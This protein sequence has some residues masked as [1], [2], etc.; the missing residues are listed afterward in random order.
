MKQSTKT[1]TKLVAA[2]LAA[3]MFLSMRGDVQTFAY[4]ASAQG[5]LDLLTGVRIAS[6][7][8]ERLTYSPRWGD[9]ST[10]VV[11]G[12]GDEPFHAGVEGEVEWKPVGTGAHLLRHTA[13]ATVYTAQFT[14]L[15][16]GISA[17]EG[18]GGTN[19]TWAADK[20]HLVTADVVVPSGVSLT[21]M[22]GAIV[23]F[24]TGTSLRVKD[25][26]SCTAKGVVFTHVDD[27]TVGGDVLCD[28]GR[29]AVPMGDYAISGSLIDDDT[30]EYRYLPPQLL[31]GNVSGDV[32]LR[33]HRT[34]IVSNS[35]TVAS[36]ATLTISAGAI[37]KFNAGCSL[38]VNGSLDVRGT[39]AA[40]IVFTS[41]KD[42]AHGGDTNGDGDATVASGGDWDGIWIDGKAD[43]AYAKMMYS[44]SWNESGIIQTTGGALSMTGCTLAHARN[45]GVWN[46][47]GSV[48]ATN[49]VFFDTGWATAP[50]RGTHNEFVN[51]VFYGNDVGICYWSHWS[52]KP[53]YRNCVFSNCGK[54]WCER[55]S[56]SYGDPPNAVEVFNSLFWNP[57]GE[58]LQSCGAVGSNGNIWGDPGFVDP[59]NGDFRILAASPCVD[60]GDGTAVSETDFYGRPRMDVVKVEDTGVPNVDGICPD[61]GIYEVDGWAAVD[62]ADF[63]LVGGV[64]VDASDG[65]VV[66]G[67]E[68]AISYVVTNLLETVEGTWRDRVSFVSDTGR[69]VEVAVVESSGI[70]RKGAAVTFSR[71]VRVP[72][73]DEG[74]WRVA[75]DVNPWRDVFE[76]SGVDN[77]SG[78][79]E[80]AVKVVLPSASLSETATGVVDRGA[81]ILRKFVAPSD[82]DY[83]L[84]ISAPAGSTVAYAVGAVPSAGMAMRVA[85]GEDGVVRVS[86]PAGA[87]VYVEVSGDARGSVAMRP[88]KAG[89]S[90]LDVFPA[91]LPQSGEVTLA[92]AG[93]HF[94]EGV[95]VR[96]VDGA[97]SVEAEAV[98]VE[99]AE[100][101]SARFDCAGLSAGTT[102][103]LVVGDDGAEA[104]LENAVR[105]TGEKGAAK[106]E[107]SLDMPS[108]LRQGRSFTF[109]IDYANTGNVD[110]PAPVFTVTSDELVFTTDS[111]V[112]SNSVRVIGLGAAGS[113]GTLRPGES[114]RMAVT[115]KVK[116]SG[117]SN[118]RVSY[119]LSSS[120]TGAEG[121]EEPLDLS[122]FFSDD[123]VYWHGESEQDEFDAIAET[124]G[125]TW[126]DFYRNFGAYLTYLDGYGAASHDYEAMAQSF[127]RHCQS[128]VRE[129]MREA[130]SVQPVAALCLGGNARAADSSDVE[131]VISADGEET[132]WRIPE[133]TT[134]RSWI[135][136]TSSATLRNRTQRHHE[137]LL[138]DNSWPGDVWVF[139]AAESGST[140]RYA[141]WNR[142]W[143]TDE[144]GGGISRQWIA[145][146]KTYLLCHGNLHSIHSKWIFDMAKAL[147]TREPGC[148]VLAIDWGDFSTMSSY[149]T[150]ERD[151]IFRKLEEDATLINGEDDF[152]VWTGTGY[153]SIVASVLNSVKNN[154][155]DFDRKASRS[156]IENIDPYK[157]FQPPLFR[158]PL[159]E[160]ADVTA[161][162]LPAVAAVAFQRLKNVGVP[163]GLLTLIGHSHGSHVA[164]GV[165]GWYARE[166][167][168]IS[169]LIGLETS[170]MFPHRNNV[171]EGLKFGKLWD[172]D[173]A[174]VSEFY[175]SSYWMSMGSTG[176]DGKKQV[177]G[178]YNF[179]LVGLCDSNRRFTE[180]HFEYQEMVGGD[181][182]HLREFDA[183]T[184]EG[185]MG[186][187]RHDSVEF[188]FIDTIVNK[189]KWA[190]LGFNWQGDKTRSAS[191][192]AFGMPVDVAARHKQKYHGVINT[193]RG[194]LELARPEGWEGEWR[195]EEQVLAE[196]RKLNP[197]LDSLQDNVTQAIEY[198]MKDVKVPYSKAKGCYID[199]EDNTVSFMVENAADNLSVDYADVDKFWMRSRNKAW[200]PWQ[201]D[202]GVGVWLCRPNEADG[203][204]VEELADATIDEVREKCRHFQRIRSMK[205][206]SLEKFTKPQREMSDKFALDVPD[207]FG[208]HEIDSEDG[209][210]FLLVIGAGVSSK[211]DDNEISDDY[212]GDL[213]PS[214]NWF[215]KAVTVMPVS[216]P[217]IK[218]EGHGLREDGDEVHGLREDG[219]EVNVKCGP[220]GTSVKLQ[221]NADRC[222]KKVKE[223]MWVSALDPEFGDRDGKKTSWKIEMPLSVNSK[224]TAVTLLVTYK[225][226]TTKETTVI[227]RITRK[228]NPPKDPNGGGS[229]DT[230]QSWDPNEMAGPLGAGDFLT[231]RYAKAGGWMTY[232]VFFENKPEATA[233]AQFV[234]VDNPL[235]PYLDWSTFEM[236]DVGFGTQTDT[237]LVGVKSGMSEVTMDGTNLAVRTEVSLDEKTGVVSWLMRIVSPQGDS[238]GWPYADDPTGFLPP[239][240]P[241][242]HC[243]EGHLTYRVK[244]RDDVPEGVVITN[245]A[246]IVFDYN[247][248][249]ETDPA[250]WNT[251]GNVPFDAADPKDDT[252]KG[253]VNWTL[254]STRTSFARTLRDDDPADVFKI[255]G[256]DGCL[257][258]IAIEK[259]NDNCDAVFSI[260][261]ANGKTVVD[262]NGNPVANVASARCIVL[263][264]TSKPYYLVVKHG[265][266]A[267]TGGR[268][269]IAGLCADVGSIKFA[270]TAVTVKE[271]VVYADVTVNRTGKDG[272]VR[273]RYAMADGTA[274]AGEDYQTTVGVLEW[275]NGDRKAK[276]IRIPLIPDLVAAYDGVKAKTF[277]VR[278]AAMGES[279]MAA[280]EYP[281]TIVGGDT[282]TVTITETSK[283]GVTIASVY[284]KQAAKRATVKK[285]EDVPLSSGTFFGVVEEDGNRLTNGLP[286]LA[287]I[288]FTASAAATPA[289]SAKVAI[290]GKTYAFSAK[291]WDDAAD[292][293][294][295][296]VRTRTLVNVQ[297]AGKIAYTNTLTV[298]VRD[299]ATTDWDVAIYGDAPDHGGAAAGALG[300][301]DAPDHGGM[302]VGAWPGADATVELMMNV[303]DAKGKSFQTGVRYAG[304]LYRQNAK[305]QAYLDAALKFA[306]YYTVALVADGGAGRPALPDGGT[307]A[308]SAGRPALPD[309]GTD[310]QS[311]GRDVPVAPNGG[312][313]D[314]DGSIGNGYLTLTLDNK[315]NAKVAGMLANGATKP[316]AAPKACAVVADGS[317]ANGLALLVPVHFAKGT[318]CFGGT[319]RLYAV[320]DATNPDG[321]GIRIVADAASPLA[322]HDDSAVG[323]VAIHGDGK[324]IPLTP[325]GG[326]YDKVVN[327]QRYYLGHALAVDMADVTAFPADELPD[328]YRFVEGVSPDGFV[329][330]LENDKIVYD[331]KKI[332]KTNR[333]TDFALSTNVCNVSVKLARA[334]G[335]VT[336]GFSLW[337]TSADGAKQK[338]LTGFKAYGVLLLA[339][340]PAAP[341]DEDVIAPG[342][343]TKKVKTTYL[344]EKGKKKTLTWSFSAPFNIVAE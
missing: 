34:Y 316:S 232:T 2:T 216:Q 104:R 295:P 280:D 36:G 226:G 132:L 92:V 256:R 312:R 193:Y 117:V 83:A 292:G 129:A 308:Q 41:L 210:K 35:V 31:T 305:I 200:G 281:A 152:L 93:L 107:A 245:S 171:D 81:S 299:G 55:N 85:V 26:G 144:T 146:A 334:T 136:P 5:R 243:G 191:A 268:Y 298:A 310:A 181:W 248:P 60:A 128:E 297:R 321:S 165:A 97:S 158:H 262:V 96:L 124:M 234:T 79:S 100:G 337:G 239:N 29:D 134:D 242:T 327:L 328:G 189:E 50:Y 306:G 231:E 228:R 147:K 185:R 25:D 173:S 140:W 338:E 151:N 22:P 84:E 77:N 235:S 76:K 322:W 113:A 71:S 217:A 91:E 223:Y 179:M 118:G 275:A 187:K 52:G 183:D 68:I 335:L 203:E 69:T 320:E 294:A 304:A 195:Y 148:N 133:L 175:K 70:I 340:D 251:I 344:D 325:C 270:R 319:L 176:T 141:V 72:A 227:V 276:K 192:E 287:S 18:I 329:L 241:E 333:L 301:G 324:K 261:N 43:I 106:L 282:C 255:T 296:T 174:R 290:G 109:Y 153:A 314:D 267:K 180:D 8:T 207:K 115:A 332:V 143:Q 219:D 39:R 56:N 53:V 212:F 12:V 116:V 135:E 269:T 38:T 156:T 66:P 126:V 237:G 208:R 317:S 343:A 311:V 45:D 47:G 230:P 16:D 257:Y 28:G 169:R 326:W 288:T 95:A 88:F 318:V 186:A 286:K 229:S 62:P 220:D 155:D 194:R 78:V 279:E 49:T 238:N 159:P 7:S 32:R 249:I 204:G 254:K 101:L 110:M 82:S 293:G 102:Y 87:T 302:V 13:G 61:I 14:V 30:T 75:V 202:L 260:T 172:G 273:V 20:I 114:F 59:D 44:G 199:E 51:C 4:G 263:P 206:D 112:Y 205:I 11:E 323:C 125:A 211:C 188:W 285:D 80:E 309:G 139:N 57:V 48:S 218:I 283:E 3:G 157:N 303:P 161:V 27:D 225:D 331:K 258:E 330:A 6:G 162:K 105:V 33:G 40:P 198:R 86:V 250:W 168:K 336:G 108:S 98:Q 127:A 1:W 307:D 236:G 145:G 215:V 164:G 9:A 291:G 67:D 163:G 120:W 123:Y 103:A 274:K 209:E 89:L 240:D 63:A 214:N 17:H 300:Y 246:T 266:D 253:A 247:A 21:I 278:L 233:A 37:L 23:K 138:K 289:L 131:V 221:L 46:W 130:E 313:D 121:A 341:L 184:A 160:R 154:A 284:A 15:E 252:A 10:C 190:N 277:T 150:V 244:V 222:G 315:G 196:N 182:E 24:M 122:E 74:T 265:T 166:G 58:G 201:K 64:S 197:P 99:S 90:V 119:A 224:V 42:D 167:S 213:C 259:G 54:G 264:R 177:W 111:G 342:F 272:R 271:N 149:Q 170:S 19:E 94:E 178:D 339:R 137:L 65:G 142:L 73:V